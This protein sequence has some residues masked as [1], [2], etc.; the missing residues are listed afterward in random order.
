VVRAALALPAALP[1]L[2][3]LR[4][5]ALLAASMARRALG[6]EPLASA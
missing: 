1:G 4:V 5:A 6:P 2:R 3:E